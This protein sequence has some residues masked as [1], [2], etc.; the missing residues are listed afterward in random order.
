LEIFVVGEGVTLRGDT[1]THNLNCS[2]FMVSQVLDCDSLSELLSSGEVQT[3]E[4]HGGM[5]NLNYSSL[6]S[7]YLIWNFVE[8]F[9]AWRFFNKKGKVPWKEGVFHT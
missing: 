5:K 4:K 2:S 6:R 1:N 3:T 9:A 7:W 8:I